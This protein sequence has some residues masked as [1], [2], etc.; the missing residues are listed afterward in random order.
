[1]EC[2]KPVNW[3]YLGTCWKFGDN[4]SVDGDL[5]KHEFAIL[6][7]TR[8]E[9][10]RS[11][12]MGGIDPTFAQRVS[13]RDILVA[14]KR[15]AQGNPHIQGLIGIAGLEMGLVVESIPR[16][17]FRNAV[18]AGLPILP[19]CTGVT[20]MCETGDMIEVDFRIGSFKNLTRKI[21]RYFEPL[22]K[23]LLSIIAAGGWK[24]N[25]M[26]RLAEMRGQGPG[27]FDGSS[28][29]SKNSTV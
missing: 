18:N 8:P 20:G 2:R 23:R 27:T 11:H 1:M 14:G 6:R 10:L 13:P 17:S 21:A 7:E 12:V 29:S 3:I 26:R 16:G 25:V 24:A 5:M 19:H 15:F 28:T 22:D 9:I 4:V